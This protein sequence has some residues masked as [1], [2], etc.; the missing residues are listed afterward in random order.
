MSTTS[1]MTRRPLRRLRWTRRA[2]TGG[3]LLLA[4]P[5]IAQAGPANPQPAHDASTTANIVELPVR[6]TV[7]NINRSL[8]PCPSDGLTYQVEGHIVAPRHRLHDGAATTLYLHGAAVPEATWRLPDHDHAL[9]MARRGHVSVTV[10]RLGYGASGTPHGQSN[11]VGSQ[12]D[13]AHQIGRQLRTG[14]YESAT[15]VRFGRVALA[16]HSAGQVVAQIAA[17]S[18]DSFDALLVG[19][20][21]DPPTPTTA[22]MLSLVPVVATCA[23]GGEPKRPGEPGGYAYT[24]EGQVPDLLFHDAD[25]RVIEAFT[26]RHERDPC[27]AAVFTGSTMNTLLLSQVRVPVFLFYALEDALWPADTGERQRRL[28]VGSDDVT[29]FEAAGTGHMMMLERSAPTFR[30]A[31]SSWLT[32]RGF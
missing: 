5:G 21:G 32:A 10:D 27:D 19:G 11:C 3:I 15:R 31:L 25:P 13:M 12:A 26:A 9:L 18:F 2:L 30:R 4:A 14:A 28:F 1:S 6:F 23:Q 29:L 8:V 16:G 24:F 22:G 20:W 17:S 7:Q